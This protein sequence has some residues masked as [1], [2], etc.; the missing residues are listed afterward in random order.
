MNLTE[1]RL[2]AALAE[3]AE[4]IP[5]GSIA[6]LALH[7]AASG[8]AAPVDASG[9]AAPV[10]WRGTGRRRIKILAVPAAAAVA[11]VGVTLASLA[12]AGGPR[13]SR[14]LGAGPNGELLDQVPR[15][16]MQLE[17][18]MHEAVV[19]DTLTGAT[20]A[21]FRPPAPFNTFVLL[22]GAPDGRTFVLGAQDIP[23]GGR[24]TG[25]HVFSVRVNRG[26]ATHLTALPI[27]EFPS[28]GLGEL[29][30][31]AVSPGGTELAI[32]LS[33]DSVV[34]IHPNQAANVLHT[35]IE[36]Y[37]LVSGRGGQRDVKVWHATGLL[38]GPNGNQTAM[39]F[40]RSGALAFVWYGN[41]RDQGIRLLNTNSSG[42]SLLRDSRLVL[43]NPHTGAAWD[44]ALL[45]TN[46]KT[47]AAVWNNP[48]VKIS[49]HVSHGKV[50][51]TREPSE[52]EFQEFSAKT[53]ELQRTLWP[54]YG[55]QG[56][57]LVWA[58]SSGS[59]LVVVAPATRGTKSAKTILGVLS[60]NKFVPIPGAAVNMQSALAF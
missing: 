5:R 29:Y 58:N 44:D 4:E 35:Q 1:E 25:T 45:S 16:Y 39:S 57:Y 7:Q 18:A 22:A 12:V 33:I 49:G 21:K 20:L 14:P 10:M 43:P 56:E 34:H 3:T 15:Y 37:S 11:V 46:G 6:P 27:P 13:Q 8:P 41:H 17:G 60:G 24:A 31:L 32:A 48:G 36:M 30:G 55:T 50:H 42:G 40:A 19:R 53:G 2:R 52:A 38:S 47:I 28:R 23:R 51:L 9:R 54:T 59:L 26:R